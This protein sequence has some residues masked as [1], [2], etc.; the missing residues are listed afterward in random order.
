MDAKS[1]LQSFGWSEGQPLREGGLRKP[2]LVKH[3][4][5]TK[6]LGHDMN[7]ADM[8]WEKLFDGQLK[9]LEVANGSNGPSFK[10]D[11]ELV[12]RSLNKSLSPLYRMFVKGQGLSGTVGKT[13]HTR[14][15]HVVDSKKAA[16]DME[17]LTLERKRS[18]KHQNGG[19]VE[20]ATA[21]LDS[22]DKRCGYKLRKG[23]E[24]NDD[25]HIENKDDKKAT[26]VK[27][28][29]KKSEEKRSKKADKDKR[30]KESES[31]KVLEP[32]NEAREKKDQK[33]KEKEEKKEKKKEKKKDAREKKEK[34][35]KKRKS[36]DSADE[37]LPKK[38][39]KKG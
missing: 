27:R 18:R 35:K 2:I 19:D 39:R 7:Q 25:E 28:K 6:G 17:S 31:T 23:Q 21:D 4:K 22:A 9:N 12:V 1:Y 8:W 36:Q 15:K 30:K 14:E 29:G 3:K 11:Q 32:T 13:E 20:T 38:M 16:Q 24:K 26:S 34:K 10:Q 5:D 37:E 33:R